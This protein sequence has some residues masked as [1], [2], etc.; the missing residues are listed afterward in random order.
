MSDLLLKNCKLIHK[1]KP[2][3]RNILI[4]K[5]KIEKI[6]ER[7]KYAKTE[8][9]ASFNYV[10]P[11]LIDCH[12]HCREPGLTHKEDLYT[13][14][15]AAAAG[16]V[17][18]ILDMPNTKPPTLTVKDLEEKRKLAKKA[19][20]NYGFHFGSSFDNI[21]EVKKAKNVASTK[22][23]MNLST[24][25]LLVDKKEAV[26][27]IFKASKR[28]AIHAEL[29]K[30]DEALELAAKNNCRV[31]FC[32]IPG[33]YEVNAIAKA[34]KKYKNL[35]VEA[36]PHHLFLTKKAEEELGNFAK[37]LPG[38]R[39]QK[40]QDALWEGIRNGVIDTIGTDHAPHTYEEKIKK[41][42]F[43][44]GVPGLETM[45]PLLLD[46]VNK[47][48]ITLTQVARLTSKNPARIFGIQNKGIIKEGYDADLVVVDMNM[49]KEVK[50]RE[51][52]T[53]CKWS[54][55]NGWKLKGWPVLTIVNGDIVFKNRQIVAETTGKEIRFD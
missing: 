22:I 14:S 42:D 17:T 47:N 40:D 26:E 49:E 5:G 7:Y 34:K 33:E 18:T 43:P 8:I 20:V 55:Y 24:G 32:H 13:A 27:K 36:C 53:K 12:V 15:C 50:H 30:V 9:N 11:G 31:Y 39:T 19:I 16:G 38:L 21:E 45:L 35:F 2:V 52:F 10:L 6:T 23:Y 3:I 28:V 1:G 44:Y 37:M 54:P 4:K 41:D 25:K 51:Q 46:A 29:G 48:R